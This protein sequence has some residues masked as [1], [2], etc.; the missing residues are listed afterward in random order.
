[1]NKLEKV[2]VV[3]PKA[4]MTRIT[5]LNKNINKKNHSTFSENLKN[6][7]TGPQ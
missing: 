7:S 6:K 3:V 2:F 5:G 1:M 4:E